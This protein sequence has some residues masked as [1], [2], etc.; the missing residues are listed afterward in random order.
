MSGKA[1]KEIFT[2]MFD[3]ELSGKMV[4]GK[5]N[6]ISGMLYRSLEKLIDAKYAGELATPAIRMLNVETAAP[7]ELDANR[8]IPIETKP[9]SLEMKEEAQDFAPIQPRAKRIKNDEIL[10]KYGD[11]INQASAQTSLDPTLIMSVI[12]VESNGDASA[13]SSA[14]AKGL[15]QLIDSTA[16]DYGVT[17]VFDPQQN[18]EAGS[19]FLKDLMDRFGSLRTALAAYNA[20]PGN[21]TRYGGIPPFKETQAYVEKV[22]DTLHS[23]GHTAAAGEPKE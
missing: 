21:V 1:G 14:G 5:E 11:Y 10:T 12:K 3:M 4:T 9:A 22:I 13:V 16:S 15:M 20:G 19:R 8:Q 23:F 18:I 17:E 2:D 7:I 6:S